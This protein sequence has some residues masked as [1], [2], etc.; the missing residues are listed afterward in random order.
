MVLINHWITVYRR[1][2]VETMLF[3]AGVLTLTQGIINL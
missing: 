2:I 1:Q 3:V